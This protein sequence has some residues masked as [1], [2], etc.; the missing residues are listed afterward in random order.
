MIRDTPPLQPDATFS[1][2]LTEGAPR[3]LSV[4]AGVTGLARLSTRGFP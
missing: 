3:L 4:D 2:A 1:F